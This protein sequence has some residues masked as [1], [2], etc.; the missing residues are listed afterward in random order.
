LRN[1]PLCT[2][3]FELVGVLDDAFYLHFSVEE[4]EPHEML[5]LRG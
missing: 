1:V 5:N 4:L 2:L 3:S